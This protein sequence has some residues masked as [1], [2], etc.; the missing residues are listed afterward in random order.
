MNREELIVALYEMADQYPKGRLKE[1]LLL[2]AA[3]LLRDTVLIKL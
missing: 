3:E 1:V 2:A